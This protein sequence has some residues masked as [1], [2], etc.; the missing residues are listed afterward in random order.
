M[1]AVREGV[2]QDR[3]EP[4]V[5]KEQCCSTVRSAAELHLGGRPPGWPTPGR[6]RSACDQVP[7]VT[8][9]RCH[10]PPVRLGGNC[11]GATELDNVPRVAAAHLY[12]A[13]DR[14]RLL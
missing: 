9:P 11:A 8:P 10:L 6:A 1:L 14:H 5:P 12:D 4:D 3:R 2:P 13:T 7:P